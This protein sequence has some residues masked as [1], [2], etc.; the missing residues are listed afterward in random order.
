MA[1]R[2][3]SIGSTVGPLLT[4]QLSSGNT[5]PRKSLTGIPPEF[6]VH[7]PVAQRQNSGGSPGSG[8]GV[9]R[10]GSQGSLFEQ[11]AHQAK[12]LVRET[13]RQSS[14]D[15]FLAHMDK[16][17]HHAKEK[18]TEASEDSPFAAFEHLTQQTKKAVDEATKSVQEASKSAMEAGKTAAGVSRN[19][20]DD[21]TYVGKST[22]GDLTKSA[23]EA[24]AKKGLLKVSRV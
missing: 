10:Q 12:D 24:A 20:L 23:K 16:F 7:P 19:T 5:S 9:L 13:T 15:G 18:I 11:I 3:S 6:P 8:N 1:S 17:K 2:A 14:Q 22:I 4:R 21:L